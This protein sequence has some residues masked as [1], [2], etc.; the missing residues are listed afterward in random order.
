MTQTTRDLLL[1][2]AFLFAFPLVMS[3]TGWLA[4]TH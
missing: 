1:G 4:A 2:L 3:V